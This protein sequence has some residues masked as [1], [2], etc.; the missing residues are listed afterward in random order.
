M[1]PSGARATRERAASLS[2]HVLELRPQAVELH[3]LAEPGAE[4]LQGT[5]G[6]VAAAVEAAVDEALDSRPR[7]Q[8]KRRDDEGRDGDR[9]V[10]SAGERREEGLAREH[11]PDVPA[12]SATV[13]RA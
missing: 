5:A 9:E 3:V 11:E 13:T 12:P 7:G 1:T 4:L 8:E 6:V 2:N 10:R